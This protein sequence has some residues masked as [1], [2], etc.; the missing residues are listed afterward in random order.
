MAKG[1]IKAIAQ[2]QP[3]T[4]AISVTTGS[5]TTAKRGCG[6][7]HPNH[8][9]PLRRVWKE[10]SHGCQA[11]GE[12]DGAADAGERPANEQPAEAGGEDR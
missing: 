6:A 11:N 2:R 5:P 7:N 4:A 8:A 9:I 3:P 1:T 12:D 10:I